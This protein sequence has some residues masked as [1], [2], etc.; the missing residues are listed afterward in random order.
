MT[1]GSFFAALTGC[2]PLTPFAKAVAGLPP[3][4][5][6]TYRG[7]RVHVVERGAGPPLLLLHGFAA[8]T[9]SFHRLI[10]HLA[11]HFRV[12]ALDYYGF[13]YTE[14]PAEEDGF[15]TEAQLDLIRHVM[16]AKKMGASTVLGQSYGGTLA[17]LLAQADPERVERLVLVSAIA[18]FGDP[19]LWLRFAPGRWAGYP[20]SRWLLSSPTRFRSALGRA[21]YQKEVLTGEVAE[22]YRRPLLVEGLP[23]AYFAFTSAMGNGASPGLRVSQVAVPALVVAGAHDEIVPLAQSERL[24]AALPSGRLLVLPKS[25]HS[26]P[27]EEPEALAKA[28]REFA[29]VQAGDRR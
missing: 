2:A 4:D 27:E 11:D 16:E 23:R 29:G 3:D 26:S 5:F 28:V 6:L 25:G 24:A 15:G 1:I 17:L 9:Y 20:A 8:S 7:R 22:A 10:P 13:G 18:E 14:R 12:V 21:Y 19:P